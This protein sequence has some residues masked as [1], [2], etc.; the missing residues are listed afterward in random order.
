MS[1]EKSGQWDRHTANVVARASVGVA[2]SG[3]EV[4]LEAVSLVD[5]EV[6]VAEGRLALDKLKRGALGDTIRVRVEGATHRGT[7]LA[8][9]GGHG[10]DG[11]ED[12]AE[13]GGGET[14]SVFEVRSVCLLISGGSG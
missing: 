1:G 3:A 11:G 8:G 14:H 12:N 9:G 6:G 4:E 5:D 2:V 7:L 13:D 10:E